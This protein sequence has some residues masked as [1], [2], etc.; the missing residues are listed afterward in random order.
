MTFFLSPHVRRLI[1]LAIDEDD[2]AFDVTSNAFF[3]GREASAKLIA[4]APIVVAGLPVVQAVFDRVDPKVEWQLEV[5]E[6]T[7]VDQ[8]TTLATASGPAISLL[9]GERTALNF[10]QRMSGIATTS[11][12]YV[13]ALGQTDTRIVDTRKTLP[14]W[15][16]LDKY[17]VRQGGAFNHRFTLAGGV[18]IKDN[19]IAAAGGVEHAIER[20]RKQAPHTLRIEVEVD[21]FEQIRPALDGGADVIML[22]NMSTPEMVR[23]VEYIRATQTRKIFI[24]A[25][26]NITLERLEELAH[27][28]LDFISSGALTHSIAAA[29]ISMEIV[30]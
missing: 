2:L 12:S 18:M 23:C 7:A 10:L 1:D 9:R 17:A 21:A 11:A 22:D 20:V 14:G 8:G 30:A 15:R 26:G 5:E 3:E 19:H 28:G 27:I 16:E 13:Q 4:K 6:G 25:S 29:D 24:E